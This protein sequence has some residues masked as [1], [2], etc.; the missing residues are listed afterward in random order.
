MQVNAIV[1]ALDIELHDDVVVVGMI[2]DIICNLGDK[3]L[4]LTEPWPEEVM[5]ATTRLEAIA[6][7]P[8]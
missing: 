1:I 6:E 4:P 8:V 5:A 2:V 3:C 7:R